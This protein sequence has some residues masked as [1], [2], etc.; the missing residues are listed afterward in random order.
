MVAWK[1]ILERRQTQPKI[2]FSNTNFT[3]ASII[4]IAQ[5]NPLLFARKWVMEKSVGYQFYTPAQY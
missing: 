1:N 4:M 3:L 2:V 5:K